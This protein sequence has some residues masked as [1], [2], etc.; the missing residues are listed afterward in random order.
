MSDSYGNAC[1]DL[2]LRLDSGGSTGEYKTITVIECQARLDNRKC[3][4]R[5]TCI[6]RMTCEGTRVKSSDE[7]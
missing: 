6:V 1:P 5:G 4:H 2:R 3:S 7:L